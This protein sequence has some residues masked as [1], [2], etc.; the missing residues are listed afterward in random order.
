MHTNFLLI[1]L[2]SNYVDIMHHNAA[3]AVNL[4]YCKTRHESQKSYLVALMFHDFESLKAKLF[5][6]LH[7]L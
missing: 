2:Q 1:T 6:K 7:A 4:V 3:A 5:C